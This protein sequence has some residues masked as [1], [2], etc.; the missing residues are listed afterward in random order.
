MIFKSE[1]KNK[2]V[3]IFV[4]IML[5]NLIAQIQMFIDRIFLGRM[6]ILYMSA[7]GNATAPV[8]TT[9]SFVFSLSMGASILISQSVGEKDIEKLRELINSGLGFEEIETEIR[10]Y[11][12]EHAHLIFVLKSLNNMARNGR[13]SPIV[14]KAVGLLNIHILGIA[15]DIGTLQSL[16]KTRGERSA[17]KLMLEEMK[18]RGFKGG[19]VRIDHCQNS[20]GAVAFADLIRA[21]FPMADIHVSHTTGLCSFYAE[22][23]GLMVGYDES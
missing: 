5:S 1:Y 8:W 10:N 16:H 17:V 19:K 7:V 20:S 13:V 21:E 15:S 9:M 6:N 18:K 4:P 11:M 23:G 12:A 22:V 3:K 2:L 14:A